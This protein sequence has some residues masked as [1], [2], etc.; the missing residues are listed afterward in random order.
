MPFSN[1]TILP[2]SGL[3][4][5][6]TIVILAGVGVL[7]Y[8]SEALGWAFC[9]LTSPGY[10]SSILAISPAA[11]FTVAVEALVTLLI[12]S[13]RPTWARGPGTPVLAAVCGVVWTRAL[14]R[15]QDA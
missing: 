3:D 14:F 5:S 12:P 4:L 10:I 7:L 6:L 8:L 13:A 11:G 1:P 9:G 15:G 2:V